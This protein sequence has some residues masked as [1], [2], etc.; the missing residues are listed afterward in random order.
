MLSFCRDKRDNSM[1]C[2]VSMIS[3]ICGLPA[4]MILFV[5]GCVWILS[6]PSL[7][8]SLP[9]F[10][11]LSLCVPHMKYGMDVKQSLGQKS[12]SLLW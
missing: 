6:N 2:V 8:P 3:N 11:S 1:A 5:C 7:P 12:V 10:L 4:T 9:L